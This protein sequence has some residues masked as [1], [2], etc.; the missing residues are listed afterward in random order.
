M[1]SLTQDKAGV[2]MANRH[3]VDMGF[4]GSVRAHARKRT[5]ADI[6][7]DA[8]AVDLFTG[9]TD[10]EAGRPP[11]YRKIKQPSVADALGIKYDPNA[12]PDKSE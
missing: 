12:D 5:H 2:S 9:D 3:Q 1:E 6:I 11:V 8:Q 10:Q 7:R 4:F